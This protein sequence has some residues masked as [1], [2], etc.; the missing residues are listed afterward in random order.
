MVYWQCLGDGNY[1]NHDSKYWV[2]YIFGVCTLQRLVDSRHCDVLS[3]NCQQNLGRIGCDILKQ[4]MPCM[5]SKEGKSHYRF[6]C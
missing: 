1:A 3:R 6:Y 5:E 4:I 2:G